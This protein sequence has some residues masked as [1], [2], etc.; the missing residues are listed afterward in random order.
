VRTVFKTEKRKRVKVWVDE[1]LVKRA[2]E[3]LGTRTDT[4]TIHEALKRLIEME[5]CWRL[6]STSSRGTLHGGTHD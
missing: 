2:K 5:E 1:A 4:E 3:L 6:A